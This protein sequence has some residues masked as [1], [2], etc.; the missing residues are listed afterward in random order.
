MLR[1]RHIEKLLD[2]LPSLTEIFR[3]VSYIEH[4][5][6][7]LLNPAHAAR[8]VAVG[9]NNGVWVLAMSAS[10]RRIASHGKHPKDA[11]KILLRLGTTDVAAYEDVFV[12]GEYEIADLGY[13]PEISS[14]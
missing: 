10:D 1:F 4:V 12:R 9:E 8:P 11:R 13:E 2:A 3:L 5:S 14:M 6:Y 7:A